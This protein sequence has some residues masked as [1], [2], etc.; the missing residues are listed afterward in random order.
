MNARTWVGMAG[1]VAGLLGAMA[2]A[3]AEQTGSVNLRVDTNG[4]LAAAGTPVSGG[5]PFPMGALATVDHL[6]LKTAQGAT[7]PANYRVLASWPDGSVKAALISLT[8]TPQA[9]VYPSLILDYGPAVSHAATGPAQV[10]QDAASL[11]VTTDVL[12]LQFS[13]AR[14]SVLE[15]AWTDLNGDGVFDASEQWLTAPADLIVVDKK[16]GR[17]FKSS[18]WTS[19]DGY[20]PKLVEVG[21]QKVTVLLEGRLKGVGGGLTADGDATLAQAKIWLSIFAGSPMVE[22]QTTLVDTVSRNSEQFSSNI[23]DLSN[24]ALEIPTALSNASYAAGGEGGVLY[25]G[26]VGGGASLLQDATPTFTTQF[27]YNFSYGGVGSGAKAP[28]WMDFS[29]GARGAGIG[30][31]HFWQNFPGKLSMSGSGVIRLDLVPVE[32]P[33]SFYTVFPGVGKTY[34]GFLDLHAGGYTTT[35]RRRAELALVPPLLIADPS[36]YA[37]SQALGPLSPRSSASVAWDTKMENQYNCIALRVGCTTYPQLYGQRDFGDYQLG[38]ATLSTGATAPEYGDGHYEDA[39]AFLLQFA[40]TGDRKWFDYAAPGARHHYDLDVM[41]TANPA[42]YPGFPAGKIHWHGSGAHEGSAIETGHVVPGGLDEYYLLTGDPR[43]LEVIREQGDWVEHWARNGAGRIAPEQSGDSV[44]LDEYERPTAWTLYTVVKAY[45]ATG[46]PK[47][48]EGASILVKNT[49]DWWKM[50]QDV[51]VFDPNRQLD[52]TQSPQSQALYYMRSDWTQGTGYPIPTLRVDNCASSSAPYSNYAYQTHIPIAWMSGLLQTALI[53]YYQDLERKG[54]AYSATVMYRGQATPVTVDTATMREMLIQILNMAVDHSFLG[55]PK[56]PS[57]YPWLSSLGYNHFIYSACP[58][59]DPNNDVGGE[60]LQWPMLFISSFNQ[61]DVSSRWQT[62]WAQLQAKWREIAL[63]QYANMVVNAQEAFPGYNGA[64]HMWNAPFAL[65][66]YEALGLLT[67]GSLPPPPPP[68]SGGGTGGGTPLPPPPP[69]PASTSLPAYQVMVNDGN[70]FL[71]SPI[72]DL[73]MT[74]PS[75]A[76]QMNVSTSGFGQGAWQA[77]GELH[78]FGLPPGAGTKTLYVQFRDAQGVALASIAKTVV[79]LQP[80]FVGDVDLALDDVRDTFVFSNNV[81]GNFANQPVV[82]AGTYDVGYDYWGLFSFAIPP[83]P[84]GVGVTVKS[85][86]LNV[87]LTDNV[88]NAS[89]SMTPYA[90]TQAWDEE[91]VTWNRRPVLGSTAIGAGL[92]FTDRSEL[93]RWKTFQLSTGTVQSWFGA[94]ANAFGIALVGDGT[95]GFTKVDVVSSEAFNASDDLR[96]RLVLRLGLSS[97]DSTPPVITNVQAA[98]TGNTSATIQWTT[99]EPANGSVEYGTTTSYGTAAPAQTSLSTMHAIVLSNLTAQTTYHARV[100][101][102]DGA[103]NAAT[104]ADMTFLTAAALK[105]DVNRDGQLTSADVPPM[106]GQLLGLSPA[107][108]DTADLNG[109][110]RVTVADLQL[111]VNQL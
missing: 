106:L 27:A 10:T 39:H 90:P 80:G 98:N 109:D 3:S 102:Q 89:Q 15:Q 61:S 4:A 107:T 91:T 37:A 36:W 55:A 9:D 92:L 5:V 93:N 76:T 35:V 22:L 46:D 103:G 85:A 110:G 71:T 108:L 31:R 83:V 111:L 2:L 96:P 40:R 13:K 72:A 52:L 16:T 38:Y 7:V 78:G 24:V 63:T 54:G 86:A 25:Q 48:W 11:T 62:N 70:P 105:G 45:E 59:R 67:G 74:A 95:P 104:S 53:R 94:P 49:I 32:S 84:Q 100:T 64:P 21:P 65:A 75:Q 79:L 88:R 66:K 19:G 58:G 41:H 43:A 12:K 99:D 34:E 51:I 8:P 81:D 69:A 28:G 26:Q 56:Y 30:M 1:A 29:S 101:S 42:R 68:P 17:I 87:Y 14:F 18:L 97:S 47:Y 60:Y 82:S 73:F 23:L 20:A 57:K 33:R 50:P 6:Q 77:V 44:G